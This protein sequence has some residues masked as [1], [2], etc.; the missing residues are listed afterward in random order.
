MKV[1]YFYFL[2]EILPRKII[3]YDL[4][5]FV[6]NSEDITSAKIGSPPD[7]GCTSPGYEIGAE[8]RA[9]GSTRLR[10]LGK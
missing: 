6:I 10:D 9:L 4:V 5:C 7:M 3:N 2:W 1:C 8:F